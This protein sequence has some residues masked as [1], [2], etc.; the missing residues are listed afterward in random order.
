MDQ[1]RPWRDMTPETPGGRY[2]RRFWQPICRSIDLGSTHPILIPV[3]GESWVLFRDG[4]G[5]PRLLESNCPHRGTGLQHGRVFDGR[6][7]CRHHGLEFE[8]DGSCRER[9]TPLRS[10]P[11]IEKYGLIFGFYGRGDPPPPLVIPELEDR[12]R[13]SALPPDVWPCPFFARLENTLDLRHVATTHALSGVGGVSV[14]A[15]TFTSSPAGLE[16]DLPIGV[17]RYRAPNRLV[18]P[19]PRDGGWAEVVC[20]RVPIDSTSCVSFSVGPGVSG[21]EARLSNPYLPSK[22][23]QIGQSIVDGQCRLEDCSNES[24]LTEIEDYVVLVGADWDIDEPS[25]QDR[26]VLALRKHWKRCVR[27]S[28]QSGSSHSG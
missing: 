24:G 8:G 3:L 21:G 2:L 15:A 4:S 27:E 16:V 11:T 19:V 23:A 7:R 13:C 22:V 28:E 25:E 1:D 26:G 12:D 5:F 14:S 20:F 10:R 17:L 6:L 18:F 9:G